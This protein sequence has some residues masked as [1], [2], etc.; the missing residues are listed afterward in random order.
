MLLKVEISMTNSNYFCRSAQVR[1]FELLPLILTFL[2]SYLGNSVIQPSIF[3]F[4]TILRAILSIPSSMIL[5]RL[6]FLVT[7]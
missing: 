2:F 5:A 4:W 7:I 1:R 6:I 3:R